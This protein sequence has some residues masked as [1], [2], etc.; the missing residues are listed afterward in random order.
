MREDKEREREREREREDKAR[1]KGG[2]GV[3]KASRI[4]LSISILPYLH[5]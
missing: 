4:L 5:F 1:G 3:F 2:K